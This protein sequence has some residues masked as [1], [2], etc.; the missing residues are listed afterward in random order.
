MSFNQNDDFFTNLL[1]G[2][3][4]R[5]GIETVV[6]IT[7]TEHVVGDGIRELDLSSRQCKFKDEVGNDTD[8]FGV[9][10]EK[11]CKLA[12]AIRYLQK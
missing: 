12:C 8:L 2:I 1:S 6:T 11:S 3:E 10:T 7:A 9:Y 4:I 5:A